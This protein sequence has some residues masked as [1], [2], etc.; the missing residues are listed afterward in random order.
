MTK[1]VSVQNR[2]TRGLITEAHGL[3]FPEDAC[4]STSN[5]VFTLIGE[6]TRRLGIDIE[7]N[8]TLSSIAWSG[9]AIST[10]R[11]RNAGGDGET[12]VIVLQVG[13]T[14]Y[15]FESSE[16]TV[17]AP[18][19]TTQL[20]STVSITAFQAQSNSETVS[21]TECQYAAGNGYLF[22][23]HPDCDPFYCTFN[24]GTVTANIITLQIRDFLG[25]YPEPGNL[26]VNVRPGSLTAEHQ[27]NLENQGWTGAPAWSVQIDVSN[28]DFAD[29]FTCPTEQ[30]LELNPTTLTFTV[31]SGLSIESSQVVSLSWNV[32]A[33]F[34]YNTNGGLH[35]QLLYNQSSSATGSVVSYSDTTLKIDV[36]NTIPITYSSFQIVSTSVVALGYPEGTTISITPGVVNNSIQTFFSD[37]GVYPANCDVWYTFK[38]DTGTFDPSTTYSNVLLSTTQAPQGHFILS[39]FNMNQSGVSGVSGVTN[40]QT[41]A[42]PSTGCFFQGRVWFTGVNSSQPASGD[43]N[44]YTWSENIYFSQI[45]TPG[46]VSTFGCCYQINDPTDENFNSLLPTDGGVITIQGCGAIYKL[47]PM[48]N[49]VLVFAQ[50]GVWVISGSSGLGFTADNYMISRISTVQSISSYS[51]VDV[52]GLPYFWNEEGIY[53]V[54]PGQNNTP[55]GYG[56]LI[57]EPITIGTILTFYNDIPLDSK[58]YARGAYNPITYVLEWT[59]RSTQ[60]AGISN[61]Y[62]MDSVLNLNLYNKA[63]YPYSVSSTYSTP[64]VAGIFYISYPNSIT[65]PSPTLKYVALCPNSQ[66]SFAEE[67]QETYMDWGT[68]SAQ[69]YTSFFITGYS[70]KGQGVSKFQPIYVKMY[71]RNTVPFAYTIQGIWDYAIDP[72][73]GQYS[74]Q[75]TVINGLGQ[76][77]YGMLFRRHKI[78][79]HGEVLQI[80]LSSVSGQ[81]FDIMGWTVL[82]QVDAGI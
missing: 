31:A 28:S 76:P 79:G 80:Y 24:Q 78:R 60:E 9:E 45:I 53:R 50:N 56:G 55:Y 5:C 17:T 15:F 71:S 23:F 38:D 22:V 27:Y 54:S 16:S 77:Y 62:Q 70:L 40:L 12:E 65:A 4:T 61:R 3:D 69:D 11:W 6:V 13:G 75:E 67:W 21:L 36:T 2:F 1:N 14:L 46:N 64:Y 29:Y 66:V 37:I 7:D 33:L 20:A 10:F 48:Q 19:S 49:G 68:V 35:G 82:E 26:A 58:I 81:P 73:S 63:F 51:Y 34:V 72:N 52:L 18:L 41:E 8:G 32:A 25:Y 39:A 30:E 74:V 59:Y 47:F 57:V 43:M 42:R 44:F